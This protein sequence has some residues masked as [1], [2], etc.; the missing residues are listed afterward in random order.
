MECVCCGEI[1]IE[2]YVNCTKIQS[3]HCKTFSHKANNKDCPE[4]VRQKTLDNLNFH[5]YS[6]SFSKSEYNTFDGDGIILFRGDEFPLMWKS[7]L[8]NYDLENMTV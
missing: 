4:Y 5:D 3:F 1:H 8:Q 7:K 2:D 6:T